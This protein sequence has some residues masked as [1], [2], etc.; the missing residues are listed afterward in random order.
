MN[1]NREFESAFKDDPMDSK[2]LNP[3]PLA[4]F[5]QCVTLGYNEGSTERRITRWI[6]Q[7]EKE[8]RG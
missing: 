4:S 1:I 6:R 8:N 3:H 2:D 7:R 5:P